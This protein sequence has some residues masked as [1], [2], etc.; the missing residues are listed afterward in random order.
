M[1]IFT[2][3]TPT[4]QGDGAVDL[5]DIFIGRELQ[6]NLF[7]I[8]LTRWKKLIFAAKPSD[9]LVTAAPSPNNKIQGLVILLY[10]R[11]GFGK[12]TLLKRYREM[13]SQDGLNLTVS[14][15]IDWEF[16]I[17]GKR[18]LFNPLQGQEIDTAE[19]FKVLCGQLAEALN[20]SPKAFQ[21]Y[22]SAVNEVEKARKEASRVIDSMQKED[23][24][25]WLRSLTVDMITT[26]LRTYVPG[27]KAVLE[28]EKVKGAIDAAAKLTQEQLS[29]L[30]AKLHNKL[31]SK[32]GDYLESSLQL[33]LALGSDLAAFARNFPLLIFFDT[34]EEVDEGDHLLRVTMGAAGL[35]VGWVIA[36]RDNLWAGFD[37]ME[38]SIALE[39]GYKDLVP[40]DRGLS[41]NFNAGDV[42]AFT[43]NDV[44]EYFALVRQKLPHEP[45][46][47]E[48]TEADAK[49]ILDVTQGV[50]L[51]VR[52]A[53]GLYVE[54]ANVDAI[55]EEVEGKR[56]IV[57]QIV[58]R[59]LMHVRTNQNERARLYGLAL[60]RRADQPTAMAVA[61]GLPPE[62]ARTSYASELSRLHRRYSFIFTEKE[63]PSLHQEVRHF[64]RLWLREHRKEPEIVAVNEQLRRAHEAALTHLEEHMQYTRLRERFQDDEWVEIYLNMT[65]QEFWLEPAEGVRYLLPFMIAAAIYRRDINE[66]AAEIGKFFA[67]NI[68]QPYRDWWKWVAASLIYKSS[69]TPSDEERSGLEKLVDLASQRCPTFPQSLPDYRMELEA[70]LWW[71]L[72]EAYQGNDDHKAWKWYEKALARL[73][74]EVELKE[75]AAEVCNALCTKLYDEKKYAESIS[76]YDKALELKHD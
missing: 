67:A 41:V 37:Q 54:T 42:G 28:H 68:R 10:G 23:R 70:A 13:A 38:R 22:Q 6:L 64:L 18:S 1:T 56:A 62:Q 31:G 74:Q 50:P 51:A 24:Y 36:G 66:D 5:S 21:E 34:Y 40:S 76:F 11:G 72:G 14:K 17:E 75:A 7:D 43:L 30:H 16:A 12:S 59:Y 49:H 44:T 52:I 73:D 57:D 2:S 71:R 3:R 9:Y 32:L 27:S 15:V 19:Y 39:Y 8:Y 20:K 46:L 35:R 63:Q 47:P 58:R 69:H 4:D 65:E 33:G 48:L 53:T 45:S 61:L 25:S 26:A 55:T 60:L 29:Q